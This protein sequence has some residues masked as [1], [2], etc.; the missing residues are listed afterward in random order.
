VILAEQ[1]DTTFH[2][3]DDLRTFTTVPVLAAIPVI[4]LGRGRQV[5]RA[6]FVSASIILVVGLTAF[7]AAY[8]ARG[9]EDIVRLLAHAA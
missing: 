3:L 4:S 1:F 9:N 5:G 7:A 8:L 2:S 6:V